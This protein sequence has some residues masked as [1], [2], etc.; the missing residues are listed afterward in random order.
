MTNTIPNPMD[1]Q[2]DELILARIQRDYLQDQLNEIATALYVRATIQCENDVVGGVN[3][4]LDNWKEV[5]EEKEKAEGIVTEPDRLKEL[6]E[7]LEV[8]KLSLPSTDELRQ[9][10]GDD[11]G[12]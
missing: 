4:L 3:K 9:R 12:Q 8:H 11:N 7:R 5:W 10:F 1:T 6:R 2:R